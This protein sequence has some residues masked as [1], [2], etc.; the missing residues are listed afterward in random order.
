MGAARGEA[1]PRRAAIRSAR[2]PWGRRP[3]LLAGSRGRGISPKR[4]LSEPEDALLRPPGRFSGPP[5]LP[6]CWCP[7][8]VARRQPTHPPGSAS[9]VAPGE[10]VQPVLL[11]E[12]L[13]GTTRS[14]ITLKLYPELPTRWA[15]PSRLRGEG[16][17][18]FGE[19]GAA[20][21]PFT[22]PLPPVARPVRPAPA[23]VC[24]SWRPY[25]GC[26]RRTQ[27]LKASFSSGPSWVSF[28]EKDRW[29]P[30]SVA[31]ELE[32][33]AGVGLIPVVVDVVREFAY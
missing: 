3:G 20:G 26:G 22:A 32:G 9:G 30:E 25:C 27:F 19:P 16:G 15:W 17:Q 4:R 21:I 31:S 12:A 1:A 5:G 8:V 10:R 24:C 18:R 11:E 33:V 14:G 29:D 2:G 13:S 23:Q 28:H 7:E 6:T